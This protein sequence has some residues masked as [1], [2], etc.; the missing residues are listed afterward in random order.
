MDNKSKL[1]IEQIYKIGIIPVTTLHDP[2]NDAIALC[3]ALRLGGINVIEITFRADGAQKAI[4][5]IKNRFPDMLVGAG[6][7]VC[8][9]QVRAAQGSGADFIVSPGFDLGVVKCCKKMKIDIFPGCATATDYQAA[10]GCGLEVLKFFPAEQSGGVAKIKALSAPF[11]NFKIIPTGGISLDNIGDYLSEPSV[12][13]CGGSYMV[14][15]K[16]IEDKKWDK[17]T[18][19]CHMTCEKIKEIRGNG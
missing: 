19:F 11:P 10:L 18:E 3:E 5:D 4:Y 9:E 12:L 1:L 15:Q 14:A 17:I 2:E 16:L 8:E 7:V 13:A 6:T